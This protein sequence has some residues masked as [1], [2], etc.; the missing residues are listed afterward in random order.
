VENTTAATNTV[1]QVSPAMR[2]RA[3]AWNT[4]SSAS[5]TVDFRIFVL[6]QSSTNPSGLWKLQHSTD[7]ASYADLLTVD[8]SSGQSSGS[9]KLTSAAAQS[10]GTPGTTRLVT[11]ENSG[12]YTWIDFRYS[13][14]LRQAIG[15]NSS[16][17]FDIYASGGNYFALYYGNSGL[18][19]TSMYMF[20][21]PGYLYHYGDVRAQGS[22]YTGTSVGAGTGSGTAPTSTL[23]SGGSL[24]L[25]VKPV[26]ASQS[27]DGTASI[28]LAD[29]TNASA[30]TGTPSTSTCSSYTASGQSTCESHLPC[31][32]YA[33]SSCSDW[34]NESGMGSCSSYSSG[35]GNNCS[36]DTASCSGAGDQSTCEAQDDPY[37]GSCSWGGYTASSCTGSVTDCSQWNG[38]ETTCNANSLFCTWDGMGG[39]YNSVTDC[40][41]WNSDSSNCSAAGCSYNAEV[42]D[43]CSGNYNTGNCSGT[44]GAACSGTVSCASYGSSGACAAEIGCSWSSVLNLTLPDGDTCPD[45]TYW[46]YNDSSGGADV[47]ILPYTTVSPATTINH[48]TSYTLA[49]FKDKV[50]I[51]YFKKTYDCALYLTAGACTPTGC[52]AN[53][54]YCS[55]NSMD[56]T[57]S[58][59]ASCTG[60]GDQ[61]TCE[62][63]SYFSSCSGTEIKSKNW[64]VVSN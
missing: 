11:L 15:G 4:S 59:D 42:P 50:Q 41:T 43:S 8:S 21:I 52:T 38:D 12:S 63:T 13:N 7:G 2:W 16:G 44:Y 30:C 1:V 36:V 53:Y 58:G 56:N 17:G 31:V 24:G 47:V 28:W 20:S 9:L 6:P 49:A 62:A 55:W 25:K 19:S 27:L 22:V 37:G 32:W 33:G 61:G 23:Q 45:R 3:R 39:C 54:A 40:S 14:T 57:C 34:N 5:K 10:N 51:S 29:A 26:T 35:A 60:I 48:T 64:Y 18:T 46:I